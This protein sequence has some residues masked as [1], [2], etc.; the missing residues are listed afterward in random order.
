[1]SPL[2]YL[3]F[4]FILFLL[5]VLYYWYT[6]PKKLDLQRAFAHQLTT[7]S[8][9]ALAFTHAKLPEDRFENYYFDV[10]EGLIKRQIDNF[11]ITRTGIEYI[12]KPHGQLEENAKG[13]SI[14][15]VENTFECPPNWHWN[16]VT[17]NCAPQKI[18]DVA[19]VGYFKGINQYQFQTQQSNV[20]NETYHARVYARCLT[21]D[22]T[23][24]LEHCVD[25][26]IFNQILRQPID[27]SN[28]C[29]VFDICD[30]NRDYFKHRMAIDTYE[31]KE[32]EYYM[33]LH[34]ESLLQECKKPLVFSSSLMACIQKGPC[35]Q[36]DDG[37]TFPLNPPQ[38]DAYQICRGEQNYTIKCQYGLYYAD[39]GVISCAIDIK[40]ITYVDYF[41]SSFFR[42]PVSGQIYDKNIATKLSCDSELK[43]F[44]KTL[45]EPD[46]KDIYVFFDPEF[47]EPIAFKEYFFAYLGDLGGPAACYHIDRTSIQPFIL[48]AYVLASYNRGTLT[49]FLWNFIFE[50]PVV[51]EKIEKYFNRYGNLY[52]FADP[53][54]SIGMAS[55]YISFV[56]AKK[57]YTVK[58]EITR[59]QD[60][61]SGIILAY[62][63]EI[64]AISI[65]HPQI[66]VSGGLYAYFAY[67]MIRGSDY[68]RIIHFNYITQSA[69]IIDFNPTVVLSDEFIRYELLLVDGLTVTPM[70]KKMNLNVPAIRKNF[71]RFLLSRV[72]WSGD[73]EEEERT[74]R[75]HFM[76]YLQYESLKDLDNNFRI[77][78]SIKLTSPKQLTLSLENTPLAVNAEFDGD[79]KYFVRILKDIRQRFIKE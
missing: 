73:F 75:P 60:T 54:V 36:Q 44:N 30:E 26:K 33:C 41:E 42:Y 22:G 70:P 7:K 76:L 6:K 53:D 51:N 62:I 16:S 71:V 32:N 3:L 1:M 79:H 46:D 28:V 17:K 12:E 78:E 65:K 19:D 56:S 47:Y 31:L 57:L 35:W 66:D 15:G 40:S 63:M 77:V 14:V 24:S 39:D 27:T 10:D 11:A 49:A 29:V 13:F 58:K 34:G 61:G 25:N 72:L 74:L 18:C 37:F 9:P 2:S 50:K 5:L 38:D 4:S 67:S 43:F 45:T 55:N 69:D 21:V 68:V 52:T 20:A 59:T 64:P 23:F 48:S 8:S